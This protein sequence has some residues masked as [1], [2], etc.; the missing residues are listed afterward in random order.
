MVSLSEARPTALELEALRRAISKVREEKWR[1]A[2]L[3]QID[4]LRVTKRS[5]K[6]VGYYVDFELPPSLRIHGLPDEF[7]K[8]PPDAEADHPDGKNGIFF[9]VYVKEGAIAF[10][11]AASTAE[12]PEDESLI[13]FLD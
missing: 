9:L 2:L 11:E 5:E 12:W 1:S 3:R 6:T 4:V 10:M 13:T 8:H 7:N